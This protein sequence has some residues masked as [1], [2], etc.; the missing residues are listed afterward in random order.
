MPQILS[1]VEMVHKFKDKGER[2]LRGG[3]DPNERGDAA[4]VVVEATVYQ[5]FLVQ[6]LLGPFN[7]QSTQ[8]YSL[9]TE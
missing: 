7:K 5:C 1:K 3:V 8:Q 9:L 2:V 4:I 6:P